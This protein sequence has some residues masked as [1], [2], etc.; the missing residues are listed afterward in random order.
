VLVQRSGKEEGGSTGTCFSAGAEAGATAAVVVAP[1]AGFGEDTAAKDT[2]AP[3][4]E[5]PKT[6]DPYNSL[7]RF[8]IAFWTSRDY[9]VQSIEL[10]VGYGTLLMVIGILAVEGWKPIEYWEV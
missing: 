10:W 2:G 3:A 9:H 5:A 7:T 6:E 1:P 4:T 8:A